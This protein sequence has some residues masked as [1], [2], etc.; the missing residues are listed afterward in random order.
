MY[1]KIIAVGRAG[2]DAEMRY[3]PDGTAVASFSMATNRKWNRHDGSQGEE[4]I[5]FKITA[6][7]GLADICHKYVHK[8]KEVLVEGRLKPDESGNPRVWTGNDGVSHASYEITAETIKLLGGRDSQSEQGE[9]E[10][11]EPEPEEFILF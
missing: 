5:W 9:Q 11:G 1:H 7:R 10:Q 8:G 4:T 3:T 6:W 2:R